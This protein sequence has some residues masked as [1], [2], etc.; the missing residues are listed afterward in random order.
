[1]WCTGPKVKDAITLGEAWGFDYRQV[2]FVWNKDRICPGNYTITQT[3]FVLVFG[4][5]GS[6]LPERHKTNVRQ[7][8]TERP[9]E[10]SRK[11]EYVQDMIDLMYP[12]TNKLELFARRSRPGWDV[13]GN[14]TTKFDEK[15][16][17][18]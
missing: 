5:K 3:E 17:Y 9:R 16:E 10:H 18:E 2:A 7:L 13:W 6:K 8:F 14:E 15:E 4:R 1:M 12:N 11:P